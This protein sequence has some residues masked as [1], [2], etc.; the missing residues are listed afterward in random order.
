MNAHGALQNLI[1]LLIIGAFLLL[2]EVVADNRRLLVYDPLGRFLCQIGRVVPPLGIS[3]VVALRP[4]G[5]QQQHAAFLN[6]HALLLQFS[7]GFIQVV[8]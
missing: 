7:F 4:V 8:R 6:L 1:G 5:S 3:G 2:R